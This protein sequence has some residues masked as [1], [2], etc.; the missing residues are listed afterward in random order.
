VSG[1]IKIIFSLE[2]IEEFLSVAHRPKFKKYFDKDDIEQL[3]DIFEVYGEIIEVKSNL[4]LCRDP[5]DNFLLSLAK[6]ADAN[7]LITGD[8]DLLDLK[9][10]GKTK[11]IT[12]KDYLKK[13]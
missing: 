11:I 12:M 9:T 1:K 4:K 3:V 8:K 2:L 6:D 10:I 5:K 13:I 7:Y